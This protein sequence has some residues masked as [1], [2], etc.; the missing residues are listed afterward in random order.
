MSRRWTRQN[1]T[2]CVQ[3]M[4][5]D[6]YR[7]ATILNIG[8]GSMPEMGIWIQHYPDA[9]IVG[10]DPRTRQRPLTANTR[11]VKA[12]V[13]DG[14]R[15]TTPYC[16][17]CH[18]CKCPR[19]EHLVHTIMFKTISV[20][21]LAVGSPAPYFLWID[22]EGAELDVLN[23]ATKTLEQTRWI[24]VEVQNYGGM[25]RHAENIHE[26]LLAHGYVLVLKQPRTTD[27]LYRKA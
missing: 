18:S 26:W 15:D 9:K 14:T 25:N 13:G 22:V 12:L 4:E 21:E 10:A 19:Q 27:R 6:K 24:N 20:D 2:V 16:L 8:L 7:P 3:Q 17:A 1:A 5:L 11:F 23:G